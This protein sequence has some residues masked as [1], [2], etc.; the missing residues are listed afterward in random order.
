MSGDFVAYRIVGLVIAIGQYAYQLLNVFFL[1][2]CNQAF[3][4]E[5]IFRSTREL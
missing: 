2:L 4:A 3:L 1:A 5:L